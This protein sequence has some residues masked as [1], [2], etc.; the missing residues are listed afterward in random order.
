MSIIEV[1]HLKYRYP[2]TSKLVL[3]DISFSVEEGEFIGLIGRNT[4]GKSTLCYALT[5]LIPHF[6]KGGYGGTVTVAG[7]NVRN[8]DVS[9]VTAAAGLVFE[10]PFS[11]ITG[12]RFTVYEE[13]AF[14][15]ENMGLPRGE[16]IRRIEESLDLLDIRKVKDKNPFD[17]SGGQM[18][19]VAIAG[20]VA[21]KPKILVFDEPTS[22]LDPQ[23]SEEVFRVVENLTKEGITIIMAE[24][25]MDKIAKYADR[26]LLM[27]DGKVIAYDTPAAI[28]SR[29][30]L[31][32]HGIHPPAVTVIAKHLHKRKANG[33][34]PVLLT[35]LQA[36]MQEGGDRHE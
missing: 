15:L 7:L 24:Q 36:L 1:S 22:Q 31:A 5:G 13:I 21:M 6:F 19:R 9:E 16:M 27:D 4:A 14:G 8:T 11:Q 25:K 28:F 20:V 3:D 18:Q 17:L 10:N 33:T 32:E 26:V 29:D 12:S 35:E 34:Y 23:G 2:D 30:D